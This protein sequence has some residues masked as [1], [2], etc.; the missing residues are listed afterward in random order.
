MSLLGERGQSSVAT[1]GTAHLP[2]RWQDE[3]QDCI[4]NAIRPGSLCMSTT[5]LSAR[6]NKRYFPLWPG[7]QSMLSPKEATTDACMERLT[8]GFCNES[9][10][11][12][13]SGSLLTV[14]C[15]SR[16]RVRHAFEFFSYKHNGLSLSRNSWMEIVSYSFTGKRSLNGSGLFL[17]LG[18]HCFVPELFR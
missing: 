18:V 3:L 4:I 6:Y 10:L 14:F 12:F 8:S 9:L 7:F 16:K 15:F 13:S 1:T 17:V 11:I 5:D 2:Q